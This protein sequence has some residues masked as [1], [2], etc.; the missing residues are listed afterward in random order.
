MKYFGED[1]KVSEKKY[2]QFVSALITMQ[3]DSPLRAVVGSTLLGSEGFINAIKEKYLYR[4]TPDKNVP[5]LK[6]LTRPP[7]G[8]PSIHTINKLVDKVFRKDTPLSRGAKI[9]LCTKYSGQKLKK[10]GL[11]FSI[12][13]SGVCQASR[14][15]EKRIQQDRELEMEVK[16][17]ENVLA[18]SRVKTCP[19]RF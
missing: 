4:K 17:V 16:K 9:Y 5:A 19:L 11:S 8:R 13:E 7:S 2:R 3:Y 14:R 10:I 6:E 12:G 18:Q 1:K 15:F